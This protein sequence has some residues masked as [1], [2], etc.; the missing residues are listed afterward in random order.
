[1][2]LDKLR[3]VRRA[4]AAIGA[5]ACLGCAAQESSPAP[6]ATST[7]LIVA[8]TISTLCSLVRSVGGR[9]IDVTGIVPVG[10]SPETYEPKPSDVVAVSHAQ[11]LVENGLGL[12]AWLDRLLTAAAP[13]SL[14]RVILSDAIPAGEKVTGNPHLWMDP[15]YA[16]VYV[17]A[18]ES[19]LAHADPPHAAAYRENA[20]IELMRL[21]ALDKWIRN[22]IAS[23]PPDHRVMITFHD[24]WYY[25]DRRYGLKDV[26]AIEPSPGQDPSPGYF[27]HLI[28][29]ARANHVHALF[30]E[31]QYSPKLAA[32][33]QASAGI[34]VLSN[35]YDDSLDT[36]HSLT[37]YESML[38]F[39]V[40][41]IVAALRQ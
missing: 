33:L 40:A 13:R 34:K 15:N 6:A 1:M 23:V 17:R 12:E 28:A 21:T 11:V 8:C 16:A 22:Q 19:A 27:A 38:R 9:E 41:A 25:F 7:R 29:L 30:G 3:F 35:L 32:A 18:I 39:D 31:P 36:E 2:I 24:A 4:T 14:T 5:A 26:G 10:A 20:R 37:D